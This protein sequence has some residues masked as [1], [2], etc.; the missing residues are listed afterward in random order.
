MPGG[1]IQLIAVGSQGLYIV[2][3]PEISY[4][5]TVYKRHTNFSMESIQVGFFT[6]PVLTMN[7]RTTVTAPIPRNGDLVKDI[8]LVF[9]LPDIYSSDKYRFQWIPKIGN[10]I[11]HSYSLIIGGQRIDRRYG[12]WLD[13]WNELTL[14]ADKIDMYHQ[15]TSQMYEWLPFNRGQLDQVPKTE[16]ERRAWLG[17]T[18]GARSNAEPFRAKLIEQYGQERGSKIRNCEAFQDSGY[19]TALTKENIKK[20]FPF[21]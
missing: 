16:K 17:K 15:H 8:F 12:E 18:W 2:G 4:F 5:R 3:N 13:I 6:K 9:T 7:T 11:M 10:Y 1:V 20:Y 14:T 19:G 21:Y